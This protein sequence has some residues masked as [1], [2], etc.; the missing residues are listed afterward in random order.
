MNDL[1]LEALQWAWS[2]CQGWIPDANTMTEDEIKSYWHDYQDI[3][4]RAIINLSGK[5]PSE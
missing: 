1:T 5:D 4:R 2:N 3:L